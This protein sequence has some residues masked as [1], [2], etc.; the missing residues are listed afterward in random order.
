MYKT[1]GNRIAIDFKALKL[2]VTD[3]EALELL[4]AY[5]IHPVEV[6]LIDL[7]RSQ[8][9]KPYR[10]GAHP[11]EA[12]HAFDCSSFTHWLY[13]NKGLWLPRYA[14]DQRDA[15]QKTT[16]GITGDLIFTSGKYY[17]CH[18]GNIDDAVGHTGIITGEGTVI[19][20]SVNNKGVAEELLSAYLKGVEYRGIRRYIP[21]TGTVYT[22]IIPD[23]LYI[24]NSHT[25][26]WKILHWLK[27]K[28][29]R[30]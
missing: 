25:L 19:S 21:S 11:K 30:H 9:G 24:D 28:H 1:I 5:G 6:S 14:I 7:A 16:T 23:S 13:A 20:C 12:P 4:T 8:I 10:F 17:R 27:L 2:P 26:R 22:L 15:G 3:A 29:P 18:W